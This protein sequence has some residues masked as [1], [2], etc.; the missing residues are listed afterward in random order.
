MPI[1]LTSDGDRLWVEVTPSHASAWRSD[2]ALTATGVLEILAA[3]G[4]HSTDIADALYAADSDWA[5]RDDA[6]VS[7]RRSSQEQAL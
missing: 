6:E 7:R 5:V 4:C 3:K 2:A 1:R